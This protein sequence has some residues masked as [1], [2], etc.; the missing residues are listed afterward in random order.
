M[1]EFVNKYIENYVF[2]IMM[3]GIYTNTMLYAVMLHIDN[4]RDRNM[5]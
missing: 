1:K 5:G 4:R 3:I 2:C